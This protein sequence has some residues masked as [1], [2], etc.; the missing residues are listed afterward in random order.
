MQRTFNPADKLNELDIGF[1]TGSPAFDKNLPT[2]VMVHGA[3]GRSEVWH[4]QVTELKQIVNTLALDLP[5]HGRTRGKSM[6]KVEDYAQWLGRVLEGLDLGKI[7]LM[8]QSL[9]GAIVQN[10]ALLYPK[11]LKAIILVGTG[12]RLPVNPALL[13]G[14]SGS[15]EKTVD[16][17]NSYAFASGTDPQMVKQGAEF[18]KEAGPETVRDG[19]LASNRFDMQARLAEI[20]L[21]CL[22]LCGEK[23][24][25]TPVSLSTSLNQDIKGS[26]LQILPSAG[27]MLMIESPEAFNMCVRDFILNMQ[28]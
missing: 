14:L 27:H 19:F 2:L 28:A 10:T 6:E 7:F 8:G 15:F 21:P 9:G 20:N 16:T 13:E 18:M 11:L 24:K 26:V 5:G 22:I 17:I 25:M 3:G 12:A 4:N 1:K 23:D